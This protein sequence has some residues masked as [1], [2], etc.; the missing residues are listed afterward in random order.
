M[1]T[2]TP[3]PPLIKTFTQLDLHL[4]ME[5]L[6]NFVDEANFVVSPTVACDWRFIACVAIWV[7]AEIWFIT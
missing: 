3:T 7:K 1:I 6:N 4:S 5:M 2:T